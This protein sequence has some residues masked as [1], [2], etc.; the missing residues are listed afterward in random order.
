MCDIK[1]ANAGI[2]REK[3]R[4]CS[5]LSSPYTG[6]TVRGNVQHL[7]WSSPE[8]TRVCCQSAGHMSAS[9]CPAE[10]LREQDSETLLTWPD[11]F[12]LRGWRRICSPLGMSETGSRNQRCTLKSRK[13][14]G[15]LFISATKLKLEFVWRIPSLIGEFTHPGG[16]FMWTGVMLKVCV[17]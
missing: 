2:V 12:D 17:C 15:N 4:S 10:S 9:I 6:Q 13:Q 11:H 16:V 8:V 3:R 1:S 5:W 14:D 7:S